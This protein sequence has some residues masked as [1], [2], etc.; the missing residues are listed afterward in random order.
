ML[1]NN[2][3]SVVFYFCY[4]ECHCADYAK[5]AECRFAECRGAIHNASFSS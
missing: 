3:L 5:Y 4:A 2:M 1:K